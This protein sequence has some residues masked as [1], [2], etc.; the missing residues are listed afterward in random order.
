MTTDLLELTTLLMRDHGSL[1]RKQRTP[2]KTHV[3]HDEQV[4][5]IEPNSDVQDGEGLVR[6]SVQW[7]KKV[8][9]FGGTLH[10]TIPSGTWAYS[11]CV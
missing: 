10:S 8:R 2:P 6:L 11:N 5:C 1:I 9:T 4:S 7:A 3:V